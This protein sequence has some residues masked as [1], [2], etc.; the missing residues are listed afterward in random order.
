MHHMFKKFGSMKRLANLTNYVQMIYQ[1]FL[2]RS[3]QF[4]S[5]LDFIS[6]VLHYLLCTLDESIQ[7]EICTYTIKWGYLRYVNAKPSAETN[8][9]IHEYLLVLVVRIC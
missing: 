3:M 2:P 7:E 1:G 5:W 9:N 8:I 6:T 4:E